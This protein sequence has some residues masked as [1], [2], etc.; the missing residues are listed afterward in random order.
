MSNWRPEVP[1]RYNGCGLGAV[2]YGHL[3]A[4]VDKGAEL[5]QVGEC[6]RGG[7]LQAVMT[8]TCSRQGCLQS[9]ENGKQ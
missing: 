9:L 2:E 1:A 8:S 7:Q 4:A 5:G 6:G 3:S